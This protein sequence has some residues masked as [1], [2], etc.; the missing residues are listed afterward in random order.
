MVIFL[1]RYSKFFDYEYRQATYL[2]VLGKLC[3]HS[4]IVR[5]APERASMDNDG[6]KEVSGTEFNRRE[7]VI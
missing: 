4:S 3:L 6:L 1:Q 5:K 7:C 2:P